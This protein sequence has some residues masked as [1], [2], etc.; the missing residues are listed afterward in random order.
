MQKPPADIDRI[1]TLLSQ[2]LGRI[3]EQVLRIQQQREEATDFLGDVLES[4]AATLQ[5][6][7]DSL[8]QTVLAEDRADLNRTVAQ[9]IEICLAETDIP[10]VVKQQLA[11]GLPPVACA[12]KQLAVALRRALSLVMGQMQP[13]GELTLQTRCEEH[14]LVLEIECRNARRDRHLNARAATLCEFV[15]NLAGLCRVGVHDNGSL[16]LSLQLPQALASEER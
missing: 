2:C 5:E 9:T 15:A 12:P 16:L 1:T 10:V 7:M 8:I 14:E 4:E 11:N 3:D 13:G 6:L